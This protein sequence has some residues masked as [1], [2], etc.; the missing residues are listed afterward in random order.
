LNTYLAG[1]LLDLVTYGPRLLSAE[2]LRRQVDAALARYYKFLARSVLRSND[3]ELW[4]FHTESLRKLG[5][6]LHRGRLARGVVALLLDA[7]LNPKRT[8]E[9]L[10]ASLR[11]RRS[12]ARPQDERAAESL[13]GRPRAGN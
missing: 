6:P 3:S 8:C 9:G 7:A 1:A 12:A 10:L 13:D 11:E 5:Y 2:E 4:R